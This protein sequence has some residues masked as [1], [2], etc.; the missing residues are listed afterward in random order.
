MAP[1]NVCEEY[2]SDISM[3]ALSV[4][5]SVIMEDAIGAVVGTVTIA[6]KLVFPVCEDF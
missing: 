2:I 4:V 3:D 6:S 1:G 5:G